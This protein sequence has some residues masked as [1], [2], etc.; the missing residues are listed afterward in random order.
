MNA[1]AEVAEPTTEVSADDAGMQPDAINEAVRDAMASIIQKIVAVKGAAHESL[2]KSASEHAPEELVGLLKSVGVDAEPTAES[3]AP[4]LATLDAAKEIVR[5][6]VAA[7]PVADEPKG[8]APKSKKA[9]APKA[10]K[11]PKEKKEKK[12]AEFKP[13][14]VRV[15]EASAHTLPEK[16][17]RALLV[18]LPEKFYLLDEPARTGKHVHQVDPARVESCTPVMPNLDLLASTGNPYPAEPDGTVKTT[19]KYLN[20]V[21][22]SHF[23]YQHFAAN[24]EMLGRPDAEVVERIL[25]MADMTDTYET[26]LAIQD[27]LMD[28]ALYGL[29]EMFTKG[30]SRLFKVKGV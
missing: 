3:V 5:G 11:A 21:K 12:E 2:T 20:F 9:K 28:L 17:E 22:I 23:T 29:A 8:K 4:W 19:D 24:G 25:G 18:P 6:T 1:V 26:R 30:R 10:A 14:A 16:N 27:T 13:A 15:V 7:E